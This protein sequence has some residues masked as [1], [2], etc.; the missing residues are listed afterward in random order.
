M[1]LDVFK[2]S[3]AVAAAAAALLWF[4]FVGDCCLFIS[5]RF[6]LIRIPQAAVSFSHS[7]SSDRFA[8]VHH[9]FINIVCSWPHITDSPALFLAFARTAPQISMHGIAP[10]S[11]R[12]C[13]CAPLLCVGLCIWIA[14]NFHLR[15]ALAARGERIH[16]EYIC[17]YWPSSRCQS[18]K[19][20]EISLSIGCGIG[21]EQQNYN[22]IVGPKI[23]PKRCLWWVRA[24]T[25]VRECKGGHTKLTGADQFVVCQWAQLANIC[26][27]SVKFAKILM[28]FPFN[29][30]MDAAY[31]FAWNQLHAWS[32][33]HTHMLAEQ[34]SMNAARAEKRQKHTA[35]ELVDSTNIF[36]SIIYTR[37]MVRQATRLH[38]LMSTQA[39]GSVQR[40]QHPPTCCQPSV[41][42]RNMSRNEPRLA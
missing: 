16:S 12:M 33:T 8:L 36:I 11:G 7:L 24:R 2:C 31:F 38:V 26:H 28:K 1:N 41:N 6:P 40:Q 10:G 34:C 37:R 22:S 27:R 5:L 21:N 39:S 17:V 18:K 32:H 42:N 35:S 13:E 23:M 19:S 25:S 29:W 14:G 3:L 30:H 15:N 4:C 20:I 9:L